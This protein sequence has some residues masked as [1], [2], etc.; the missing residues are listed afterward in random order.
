MIRIAWT[1]IVA[2]VIVRCIAAF[3]VPLTGDEAYYWEWSRHLAFGY[4]DHPPMVA[5][6]IALFSIFGTTPGLVRLGF[7]LCGLV[8][9]LAIAG[10]ATELTDD[11]RAGAAAALALALMPLASLAFGAASPDGPYMRFWALALWFG[12]RAFRR[13][14]LSDW[15]LLGVALA[16]T[17][18][19]RVLGLALLFG[20]CA[21]AFSPQTRVM[22]R[23]GVPLTL[24]VAFVLCLPWLVWNATHGWITFAFALLYRHNEVHEL[25]FARLGGVLLA[26]TAAYS[27]GIFVAVL[28]L[29]IRP[30]NAF[31]AWAALPQLIVVMVLGLVERVEIYWI[32]GTMVSLGAMLGIAYVRISYRARLI[33]TSVCAGP[34]TILVAVIL[35]VTL[36]PVPLYGWLHREWNASL[37]NGGP[38]EIMTYAPLAHDA[39]R[40]ARAH[41]AVVMTDG[42][43]FSS[44]LDFDAGIAP[45]VIGYDWQG[46]EARRW[47]PDAR[48]PVRAL[49]VDKEPLSSRPDIA[50]HLHRACGSVVDGGV[51]GFAYGGALPRDYYFTWCDGL[52]ADGLAIL[53]WEREPVREAAQSS[54]AASHA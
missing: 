10:C 33:W 50:L 54:V 39:A 47:Y 45:V 52:A 28:L 24:G 20:V 12:A 11:G 51:H 21:Y 1:A 30:R 18:L 25:S 42:Y 40:L 22:W 7:I 3:T 8:A 13:D 19:S 36:A 32:F 27:P 43:G 9:S 53:R 5:W 44:V 48:H 14:R 49:F 16:G 35:G 34:G 6:T 37:R 38:F 26:Q 41:D 4:V 17:L 15:A 46:R 31:L 2:I 29:A 23:R